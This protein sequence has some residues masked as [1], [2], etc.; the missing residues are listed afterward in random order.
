M[1]PTTFDPK[2]PLIEESI[3]KAAELEVDDVDG[4]KVKFGTLFEHE[5]AVVIFI[6]TFSP[7]TFESRIT[8]FIHR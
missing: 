4:K 3:V 7:L 8:I 5:K 1:S 2:A 6:R